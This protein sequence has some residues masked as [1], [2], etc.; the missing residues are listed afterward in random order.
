VVVV[1]VGAG[2]AV[3]DGEGAVD[4]VDVIAAVV[5]VAGVGAGVTV[6][7]LQAETD[8]TPAISNTIGRNMVREATKDLSVS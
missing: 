4:V 3:V 1:L 5:E 8:K 6:A 2:A 7:S